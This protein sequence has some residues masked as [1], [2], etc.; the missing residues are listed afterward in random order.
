MAKFLDCY[1]DKLV[2]VF[3]RAGK[4]CALR[5]MMDFSGSNAGYC[6]VQYGNREDAKR[7][8][9]DLNNYK[10]RKGCFL[11][12]CLN[13]DNCGLFVW[14]IPLNKQNDVRRNEKCARKSC[15]CNSLPSATDKTKTVNLLSWSASLLSLQLIYLFY[16][17]RNSSTV[18]LSKVAIFWRALRTLMK[19]SFIKIKLIIYLNFL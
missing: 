4:L 14:G 7:A 19:L 1:E 9:R 15:G 13:V 10:I 6:F 17:L 18:S 11:G 12:V 3:K 16:E 5:S 8:V 2:P